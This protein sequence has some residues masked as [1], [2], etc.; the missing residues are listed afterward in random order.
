MNS[1][2]IK[3]LE[4]FIVQEPSNP[5]NKYALAMEYYES[6]PSKSLSIL[7]SLLDEH[8]AYLPTYFKTAHLLWEEEIWEKADSVFRKGIALAQNQGDEK[9]LH[10]LKS[11]YQN[12]QFDQD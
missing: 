7:Q 6:A 1:E 12:F 10:E 8:P 4:E 5:F 2:R 9:T 3:M 11:A